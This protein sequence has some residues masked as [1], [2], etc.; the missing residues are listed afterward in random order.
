LKRYTTHNKQ[1]IK[2]I[3]IKVEVKLVAYLC[4]EWLGKHG[5]YT[6][7]FTNCGHYCRRWF[8]RSLWL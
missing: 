2:A 8:P 1:S 3:I 5:L 7:C 4:T 6:G